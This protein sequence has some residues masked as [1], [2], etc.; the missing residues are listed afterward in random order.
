MINRDIAKPNTNKVSWSAGM[1]TLDHGV[2]VTEVGDAR[3][4]YCIP[5]KPLHLD[6]LLKLHA[7][8]SLYVSHLVM[9]ST[10]R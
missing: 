9:N 1:S 6:I 3:K 10:I 4:I 5:Y 2:V 8:Y 7:L